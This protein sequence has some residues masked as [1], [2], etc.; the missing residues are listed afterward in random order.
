MVLIYVHEMAPAIPEIPTTL[1]LLFIAAVLVAVT[2]TSM[3]K[4]HRD[5]TAVAHA[6]RVLAPHPE[7]GD[8][9]G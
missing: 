3:I 8:R 6:G 4:V 2:I 5:P 7:E 1:S 9:S